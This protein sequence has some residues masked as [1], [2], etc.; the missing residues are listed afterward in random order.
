MRDLRVAEAVSVWSRLVDAVNGR[1][2]VRHSVDGRVV[3]SDGQQVEA[4]VLAHRFDAR[5][6]KSTLFRTRFVEADDF[7]GSGVDYINKFVKSDADIGWVHK[8]FKGWLNRNVGDFA[9]SVVRNLNKVKVR[10]GPE[11]VLAAGHAEGQQAEGECPVLHRP[12]G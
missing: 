9:D 6:T 8:P 11:V 3:G 2:R 5:Y 4:A 12:A 7:L 1:K 10:F